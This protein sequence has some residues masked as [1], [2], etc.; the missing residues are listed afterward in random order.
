MSL[1]SLLI[2]IL[3]LALPVYAI[4]VLIWRLVL[5]DDWALSLA[6]YPLGL[7][8][9]GVIYCWFITYMRARRQSR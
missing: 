7:F 6:G 2:R 1:R 8:I 5:H 3:Y 9:G 4:A